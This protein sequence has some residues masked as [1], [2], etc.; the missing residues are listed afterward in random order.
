MPVEFG[1]LKDVLKPNF[2]SQDIN[3]NIVHNKDTTF[4]ISKNIYQ[5]EVQENIWYEL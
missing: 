5:L 4:L 3:F 1:S 2:G